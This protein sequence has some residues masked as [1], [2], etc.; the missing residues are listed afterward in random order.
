M[1]NI[2]KQVWG[3][4]NDINFTES[5]RSHWGEI[6]QGGG[7]GGGGIEKF[8]REAERKRR[9]SGREKVGGK[10]GEDTYV[11]THTHIYIPS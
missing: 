3:D 9:D 5:Q 8:L 2:S 1:S 4:K 10:E 6:E 11:N 7:G